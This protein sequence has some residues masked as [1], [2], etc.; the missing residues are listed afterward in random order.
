MI[1]CSES[2]YYYECSLRAG[3]FAID[4]LIGKVLKIDPFQQPAVYSQLE[5]EAQRVPPGSGGLLHLPYLCGVMNPYWDA[6]ARGAFIGLSSSHG[7]GHLYRSILEGIAFE[8]IFAIDAVER[9][10]GTKVEDFVAV[11][12]GATNSLWCHI[13]ADVTGRNI[14][15]PE[16]T[17]ASALGAAIAAAVGV[18]W[19]RTFREA[20]KEMTG[21]E[22]EVRPDRQ[23]H[24]RYKQFFASYKRMYPALETWT[25]SPVSGNQSSNST[26][27]Q[28]SHSG[29]GGYRPRLS[30]R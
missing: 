30:R 20:G 12:G 13:L 4:W 11:G 17:E 14:C 16:N 9:T 5:R 15:I 3:T 7:R 10:I 28:R 23:N 18:G 21:A 25:K 8:Q 6:N 22:K 24:A 1:S 26:L 27:I 19:H 29:Y 2:G